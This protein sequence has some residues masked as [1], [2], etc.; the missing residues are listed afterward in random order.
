MLYI[1]GG[2]TFNKWN[3]SKTC[4]KGPL[5]ERQIK[6]LKTNRSLMKVE[7]MQNAPFGAFCSTFDLH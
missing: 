6:V 5:E 2:Y 3:H 1:S 7:S 4:V